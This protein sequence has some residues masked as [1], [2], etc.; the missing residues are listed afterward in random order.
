MLRAMPG[1][2]GTTRGTG[3]T[4]VLSLLVR[5]GASALPALRSAPALHLCATHSSLWEHARALPTQPALP[6]LS[7]RASD[8]CGRRKH[9]S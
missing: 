7:G 1:T 6:S 8:C 2:R 3:S 9:I 4:H 5:L